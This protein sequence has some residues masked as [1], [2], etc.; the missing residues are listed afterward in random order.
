MIPPR[1]THTF[2]TTH[3]T[4]TRPPPSAEARGG[5]EALER[6]LGGTQLRG[7]LELRAALRVHLVRVRVRVRVKG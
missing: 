7:H 4:P 5:G 1:R 6:P 3:R 2:A